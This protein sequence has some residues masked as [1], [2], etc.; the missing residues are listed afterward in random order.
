M[1]EVENGGEYGNRNANLAKQSFL[2]RIFIL[3]QFT[4][5]VKLKQLIDYF[6]DFI[7]CKYFIDEN[8]NQ[9]EYDEIL[10]KIENLKNELR[11]KKLKRIIYE[12]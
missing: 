3:N 11:L 5:Y 10:K 2:N 6:N 7:D 1:K 4:D 8:N 9:L 12:N